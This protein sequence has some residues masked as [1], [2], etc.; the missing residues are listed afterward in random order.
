MKLRLVLC[1]SNPIVHDPRVEKVAGT[2]KRAGYGVLLLGWDRTGVLPQEE[3]IDEIPCYRLQIKA[4]SAEGI[5]NLPHVIRF[6][7]G[8]LYW[9]I[10]HRNDY[11]LI[12]ACDF[13]TILPALTC[14]KLWKKKVVYDIFDVYADMLRKIPKR[15]IAMIRRVDL[16]AITK[17]DGV[18][19]ADDSRM[20]QIAGARPKFYTV[21]YNSPLDLLGNFERK[22]GSPPGYLRVSY[23]GLLQFERGLFDLIDVIS[24]H[25]EWELDLGGSGPEEVKIRDRI[26]NYPNTRWHGQIPYM[27][28]LDLNVASDAMVAIFNPALPNHRYSSSNKLFEA[29]MLKKPIIVARNTNM[30]RIVQIHHC[31]IVINYGDQSA[32][33]AALHQLAQDPDLRQQLGEN[34]RLGYEQVY[35]WEKMQLRLLDFYAE[36]LRPECESV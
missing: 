25:A 15:I 14:A 32:L 24:K 30:D 12:H 17:A 5:Y 28:A 26:R 23:I 3:M 7:L 19:Q 4:N 35:N 34:G 31:G 20:D 1:R 16:W 33:E 22:P 2:L 13:D 11:D 9:L 18:I 36:I 6:Q 21:V 29:M 27:K 8:L 10:R